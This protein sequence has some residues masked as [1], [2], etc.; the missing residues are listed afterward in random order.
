MNISLR[1]LKRSSGFDNFNSIF[2][3]TGTDMTDINE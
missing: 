1:E 3:V 2:K